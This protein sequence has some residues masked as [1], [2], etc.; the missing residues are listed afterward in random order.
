MGSVGK[1]RHPVSGCP[2]A[3]TLLHICCKILRE[4]S[5][6]SHQ[7]QMPVLKLVLSVFVI[8]IVIAI[9]LINSTVLHC[10]RLVAVA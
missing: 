4:G 1:Q 6:G 5:W 8:L 2:L 3:T 9:T 10:T 7:A